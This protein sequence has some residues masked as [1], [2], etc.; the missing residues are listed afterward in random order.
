M[1]DL[2]IHMRK[3][4]TIRMDVDVLE[5]AKR[6]AHQENRTVTNYIETILRRDLHL[7]PASDG[8][9]IEVHA[10][11]DIREYELVREAGETDEMHEA[12]KRL[13]SKI[14]DAGGR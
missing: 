3:P 5:A 8:A 13:F 9:R 6:R 7:A 4:M 10:P 14:L 2:E 12:R 11:D 1:D